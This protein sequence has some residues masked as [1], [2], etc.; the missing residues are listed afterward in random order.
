MATSASTLRSSADRVVQTLGRLVTKAWFRSVETEGMEQITADRPILICANHANGFVDPVLL[1]ATSPRPV[2]FLAKSTLWKVPGVGPLLGLAGVLPV[3]RRQDDS[4]DNA[5]SFAACEAELAVDGAIGIF[6]EGT[7]N[8]TLK[9]LPLKTGAA[10]IAL[11]ARA[12]GADAVRIVPVGLLYEDKATPRTRVLVR[13]RDAIDLD[14]VWPDLVK[15][16]GRGDAD[17]HVAVDRLTA[18][19]TEALTDAYVSYDDEAHLRQLERAARIA[20]RPPGADPSRLVPMA[21][22]EPVARRLAALPPER[23]R[24]VLDEADAYTAQLDLLGLT[25]RDVVPGNTLPRLD[26]RLNRSATA[27]VVLAPLAAI[28]AGVNLPPLLAVRLVSRRPMARISRGNILMLSSLVAFPLTWL[29]SGPAGAAAPAASVARR[30]RGGTD[31]RLRRA[32][33]LGTARPGAPRQAAVAAAAA[34]ARPARRP[35]R[36]ARRRGERRRRRPRPARSGRQRLRRAGTVAPTD[37]DSHARTANAAM[38]ASRH[39]HHDP[40]HDAVEVPVDIGG[41]RGHQRHARPA[42]RQRRRHQPG[43]RAV[44]AKPPGEQQRCQHADHVDEPG[45]QIVAV[46]VPR[47]LVAGLAAQ[48]VEQHRVPP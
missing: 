2:R 25:D 41:E 6:P 4:G 48:R 13:A 40:L 37:A 33:L 27:I 19:I 20:L 3:Y 42:R 30:A 15:G 5:K 36:P 28:G 39:R 24:A 22:V 29:G 10:R 38:K 44:V 31:G 23:L 14:D 32:G 45:G 8:D 9:L 26:N 35:A 7:V 46:V 34:I 1:I 17:D 47:L 12:A 16:G 18:L 43:P 11:G 21:R